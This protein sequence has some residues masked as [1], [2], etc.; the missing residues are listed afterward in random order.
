M[1]GRTIVTLAALGAVVTAAA[2]AFGGFMPRAERTFLAAVILA[3]TAAAIG[4]AVAAERWVLRVMLH[5]P[6]RLTVPECAGL[7]GIWANAWHATED[8]TCCGGHLAWVCP[9]CGW[10][11]EAATAPAIYDAIELYLAELKSARPCR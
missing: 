9:H 3:A 2:V 7:A 5:R 11:V 4:S 6:A 8:G 10:L 1:T